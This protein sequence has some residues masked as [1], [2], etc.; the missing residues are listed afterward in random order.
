MPVVLDLA[1]VLNVVPGVGPG[2][3]S[4]DSDEIKE[5]VESRAIDT[6]VS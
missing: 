2:D 5:F 6:G 1:E 3:D 4:A